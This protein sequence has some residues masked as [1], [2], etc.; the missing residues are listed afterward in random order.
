M[1]KARRFDS[2]PPADAA[3]ARTAHRRRQHARLKRNINV[4]GEVQHEI[5]Q[6]RASMAFYIAA[7]AFSVSVFQPSTVYRSM[8]L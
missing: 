3:R 4:I 2:H 1:T 6:R 7:A 8:G 5:D